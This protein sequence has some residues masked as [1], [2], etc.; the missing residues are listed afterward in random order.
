MEVPTTDAFDNDDQ[1]EPLTAK[2]TP[3]QVGWLQAK[4]AEQNVSV[5]HILRSI[6]TAQMQ[7][8]SQALSESS[9]DSSAD[10]AAASP[11]PFRHVPTVRRRHG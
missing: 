9:G 11:P 3:K 4:A 7:Q 8:E 1:L 5:D 6:L 2:L 10:A